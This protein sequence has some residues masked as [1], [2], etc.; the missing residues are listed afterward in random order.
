MT[1]SIPSNTATRQEQLSPPDCVW[2]ITGI[3]GSGKTTTARR[4]AERLPRSALVEGDVT[5][6]MVISGNV[7]PEEEPADEGERQLNLSV[8]NQS[9]LA[10]SFFDAGF[11]PVIEWIVMSVDRLALYQSFLGDVPI[12]FVVL[13]ANEEV[14]LARHK[15]RGKYVADVWLRLYDYMKRNVGH[16]GMWVDNNTLSIDQTVDAILANADEA[17]LN[18]GP[19]KPAAGDADKPR[20]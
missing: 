11:T 14:A 16:L 1:Q 20:A 4:L 5:M 8:R 2:I 7:K 15:A 12:R 17:L 13:A 10:R 9:L 18:I 3:P 6:G 19:N